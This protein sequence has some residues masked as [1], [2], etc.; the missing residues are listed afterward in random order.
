MSYDGGSTGNALHNYLLPQ[1]NYTGYD[2]LIDAAAE[3]LYPGD[4]QIIYIIS[5]DSFYYY[6][7]GVGWT[8]LTAGGSGAVVIAPSLNVTLDKLIA[9]IPAG[10]ALA[11]IVVSKAAAGNIQVNFGTTAGGTQIGNLETVIGASC[12]LY[13]YDYMNGPTIAAFDVYISSPA[14]GGSTIDI[15]FV[16]KKI[17]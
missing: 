10:Y 7:T 17:K 12:S 15:Y 2:T 13:E 4:G 5:T 6:K 1:R 14:W 3:I 9:S 16:I 8:F 11:N